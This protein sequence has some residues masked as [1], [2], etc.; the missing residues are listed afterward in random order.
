L[1]D[2]IFSIADDIKSLE[3]LELQAKKIF[4]EDETISKAITHAYES[5]PDRIELVI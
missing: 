1:K 3:D 2:K 5:M 4:F